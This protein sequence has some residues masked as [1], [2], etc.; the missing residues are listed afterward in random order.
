MGRYLLGGKEARLPYEVEELNLR[1]YTVEELCYYIYNNL[2]LIEEDFI[3][4]RLLSFLRK[5]LGQTEI[6]EK[7]ERFYV[8]PSDQDAT[9]LM[10]LSDVGYYSEQELKEFQNRLVSRKRKNGP[11]RIL[12]KADS[13][14]AKKRYLKAV[15]YYRRIALDKE[16]GRI[17]AELR[18]RAYESMANAYG[19]LFA[20]E[21]ASEALAEAYGE[22]PQERL[23]KK[24]YD[25]SALSGEELP[26]KLFSK[27]PATLLSSWEQ[28]FRS[29]AAMKR[30]QAEDR[31]IMRSF[32]LEAPEAEKKLKDYV[33]SEKEAFR[34]MVE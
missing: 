18:S 28:E 17:S 3:D 33:E 32:F 21:R 5:E 31:E 29:R 27:V 11:E 25:V 23:L 10:L 8:S 4:E 26:E 12:Q 22:N 16:D 1:L 15:F 30:M 19:H 9:L 6:A 20:F 13:L 34:T 7:I 2:S 24:I 14:Y